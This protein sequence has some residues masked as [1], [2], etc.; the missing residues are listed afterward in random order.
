MCTLNYLKYS[1]YFI[2]YHFRFDNPASASPTPFRQLTYNYLLPVNAWLLI[3][4]C[5]LCCDWT[6]STIPL[7][8]GLW[9]VRNVATLALYACLFFAVRTVFRLEEESRVS[10][11][12]VR[13]KNILP[14]IHIH[15]PY[16]KLR[17]K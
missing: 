2:Y 8:S 13:S 4:P 14:Y 11:V 17:K 5:N 3:F 1:R 10:L 7:V 16:Q 12:M 9:D 6:M 15:I